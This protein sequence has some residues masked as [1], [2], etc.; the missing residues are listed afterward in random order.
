MG[1]GLRYYQ[2][3]PSALPGGELKIDG[4]GVKKAIGWTAWIVWVGV[5][6]LF[7]V[8]WGWLGSSPLMMEGVRQFFDNTPP[9]KVFNRNSVTLLLLGCDEE[10]NNKKQII[11]KYAR[12][13]MMLV[14]RIDF[15]TDSITAL[16]IPR[17]LGVQLP[18]YPKHK[19]NAYHNIGG[20]ELAQ[21]ATESVLG[22]NIDRTIVLDYE[23]FQKMVDSVGGVELFIEKELKYTDTWGDL[24]IDLK[25][26]RHKL[27]GY[28][29]MG[30][31]RVRKSDS[32]FARQDRQK[33]F[34]VAFKDS[35]ASN[36]TKL[37]AVAN[38]AVGLFNGSLDEREIM[39]L[40]RF[41]KGVP[42]NNIRMGMVPVRDGSGSM[43]VLDQKGLQE[44]LIEFNF[45][46]DPEAMQARSN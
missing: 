36:P 4:T 8:A 27:N 1:P 39:A 13:D 7:G 6:C 42:P 20:K 16:S 31:V 30:Y 9:E 3:V 34:L 10:R 24:Y 40:M 46:R 32:D 28:E 44:K 2:R 38:Q 17:D 33:E 25:P 5:L 29:A 43:L 12:S 23:A 22:V 21:E 26:G 35:V 14:A 45:V 18:G 11:K 41:A 37:P 15:E 19:I